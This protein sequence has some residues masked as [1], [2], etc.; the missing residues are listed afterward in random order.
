MCKNDLCVIWIMMMTK[1]PHEFV[2]QRACLTFSWLEV[3]FTAT[4]GWRNPT[5]GELLSFRDRH[6]LHPIELCLRPLGWSKR[7]GKKMHSLILLLCRSRGWWNMD[8]L[9]LRFSSKR[10]Y[11]SSANSFSEL[12]SCIWLWKLKRLVLLNLLDEIR[13]PRKLRRD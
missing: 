1:G 9:P 12:R 6:P 2:N 7:G 4:L 13:A 5:G 10:L 11:S 8:P 3:L